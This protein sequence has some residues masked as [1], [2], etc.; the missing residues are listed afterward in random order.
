M[1][2][3]LINIFKRKPKFVP[4]P[5]KSDLG[6]IVVAFVSGGTT[7]YTFE[8]ESNMPVMRWFAVR[9][10]LEALDMRMSRERLQAHCE[11]I[12]ECL[13]KAQLSKVALANEAIKD[14]LVSCVSPT[15]ILRLASVMYFDSTE[16]LYNI[17]PAHNDKKIAAWLQNG[18]LDFFLQLPIK[19]Y[20]ISTNL[21]ET[22]FEG[23]LKLATAETKLNL[24]K[25]L[26]MCKS[27][28]LPTET[29]QHLRWEM[30]TLET[31]QQYLGS[32]QPNI[33]N[34]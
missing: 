5:H 1:I 9:D 7:Y 13:N 2:N 19:K 23:Y 26:Q 21:S 6:N 11:Y 14:N 22:D 25:V 20:L 8:D 10:L 29:L 24:L 28:G 12:T 33:T 17:D 31:L 27:G 30:A 4:Y 34:T 32:E 18:A 3:K 15:V 16:N